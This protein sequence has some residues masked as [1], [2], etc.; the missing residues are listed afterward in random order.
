[1]KPLMNGK[2]FLKDNM[3]WCATYNCSNSSKN[4]PD[5]TC[6]ILPKR[7]CTKIAWIAAVNQKED[8][9]SK[10]FYLCSDHFEGAFFDK[11][12][13]L[14]AYLFYISRSKERK[15]VDGFIGPVT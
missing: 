14:Q 12:W 6:F 13:A 3:S 5:K 11:S 9:L 1:M 2:H 4:N 10:D 8:T 15:L 7:E